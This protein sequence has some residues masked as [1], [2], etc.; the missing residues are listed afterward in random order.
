MKFL[1]RTLLF[2][3][4][5]CGFLALPMQAKAID[6][7]TYIRAE[8]I[9]IL[10][11]ERTKTGNTIGI[12]QTVELR[13][14]DNNELIQSQTSYQVSSDKDS[15][16]LKPGQIVVISPQNVAGN[17]EY[18]LVDV[19][20][21]PQLTQLAI[22]FIVITILVTQKKG[23]LSFISLGGSA[24]V[25]VAYTIPQ[26]LSGANPLMVSFVSALL[27]SALIVY[28]TH[29]ISA[30]SHT[31][32]GS[33]VA[34]L[35]GVSL[36]SS[37]AV[38]IT[39]LSGTGNEEAFFLQLDPTIQINLQGLLLGGIMLATLSVLDDSVIS[40][41]SVV[42]QLRHA[43]PRMSMRELFLRAMEVGKDHVSTLVNT[44][45]LAYAGSSL[46]LFI[47]FTRSAL[48]W[49][50]ALNDQMIAEEIVRTLVGSIGLVLSIPLTTAIASFVA[51]RG[52]HALD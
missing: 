18:A 10:D 39:G 31:A 9:R 51:S 36:L 29:G 40:Q 26:I 22:L 46:P 35:S 32:V 15:R 5:I 33:M 17:L 45:F 14:K 23:I 43:N 21:V 4:C 12:T 28:P 44:L 34:V 2:L 38:R 13:R 25:L 20:R 19:Y 3:L 49:W 41:I 48:P 30:L 50:V 52:K 1:F 7:T 47:L 6:E 27:I 42:R 37:L 16:K 8:V 24:V 11:E